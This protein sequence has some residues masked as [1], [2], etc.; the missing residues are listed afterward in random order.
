MSSQVLSGIVDQLTQLLNQTNPYLNSVYATVA[1]Y[2]ANKQSGEI[3]RYYKN[4][5]MH[6][7][8]SSTQIC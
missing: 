4:M 1:G 6:V 3:T 7:N 5:Q 2:D 8:I